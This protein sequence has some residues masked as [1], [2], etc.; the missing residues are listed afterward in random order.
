VKVACGQIDCVEGDV[1]TNL[2][3]HLD[4][5]R[6]A[7]AEGADLIVFPELSLT[8]SKIGPDVPDVSLSLESEALEQICEASHRID[9]VVGLVERSESNLYNR[10]NS[11]FYFSK[12]RLVHR[13]RKLFLVNYAVFEEGKHYVPGN[14]LQAFDCDHGRLCLLVCNDV[15]HSPTPYIAALD[16]AEMLIVPTNS[17][18]GTLEENLDIAGTWEA[19]NR[20]YAAMMGFYYVFVNRVGTRQSV[21]GAFPYWGGSEILGPDGESIVKA[22]YDEEALI[23]GEVDIDRVAAQRFNAPIIRDARLWLIQQEIDRLAVKR[24]EEVRLPGR[25]IPLGTDGNEAG[26]WKSNGD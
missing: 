3:H 19:M 11:A 22:P 12:C 25:R 6:Q 4:F 15:W 2:A 20:A 7:E 9:I 1:D 8:G 24:S 18:R 10:Y 13:H 23:V 16:G 21:D 14:N 17:A 26:D 5:I